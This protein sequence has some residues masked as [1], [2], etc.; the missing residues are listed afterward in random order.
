MPNRKQELEEG[1]AAN[2]RKLEELGNGGAEHPAK[3]QPRAV[4]RGRGGRGMQ[5]PREA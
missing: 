1:E 4:D 2:A 3:L 5:E